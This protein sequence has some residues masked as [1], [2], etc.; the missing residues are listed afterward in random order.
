MKRRDTKSGASRMPRPTDEVG[1]KLMRCRIRQ[2][3]PLEGKLARASE[4]DEVE[5]SQVCAP[6]R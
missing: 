5:T 3:L 1:E 6:G 2:G 4:T